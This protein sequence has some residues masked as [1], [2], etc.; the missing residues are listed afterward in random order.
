V[1]DY[2]PDALLIQDRI[3]L[4]DHE[5]RLRVL[6]GVNT[7]SL[8]TIAFLI[9]LQWFGIGSLANLLKLLGGHNP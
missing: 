5:R 6:E 3:Q 2:V 7:W 9:V 8:L 4:G 1:K